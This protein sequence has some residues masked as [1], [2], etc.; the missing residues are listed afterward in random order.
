MTLLSCTKITLYMS[1][2]EQFWE[3]AWTKSCSKLRGKRGNSRMQRDVYIWKVV[4]K[5]YPK[6]T[7]PEKIIEIHCEIVKKNC[8]CLPCKII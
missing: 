5:T 8:G 6:E 3:Y 4:K 7:S 2:V 1:L